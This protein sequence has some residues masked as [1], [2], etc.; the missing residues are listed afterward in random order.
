MQ[1]FF[2]LA[3]S[4]L[5]FS[6]LADESS[7]HLKEGLGKDIVAAQCSICHSTDMIQMNSPFLDKKAWEGVVNKMVKDMGAP[8]PENDIPVV[9][10]YLSKNYGK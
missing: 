8:L 5:S 3:L 6:A 1:K 4:L 2:M 10:E 7:I 9:V